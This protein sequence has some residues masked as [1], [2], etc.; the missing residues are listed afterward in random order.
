MINLEQSPVHSDP[1]VMGGALVF[2][3][4]RVKVQAL[5]DYLSAG[6]TLEVFLEHFPTVNRQN[7][8]DFLKLAHEDSH[9]G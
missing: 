7:A 6:E 3:G 5:L 4:T 1:E 9:I 2:R 8:L